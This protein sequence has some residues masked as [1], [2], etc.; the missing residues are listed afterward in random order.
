MQLLEER[1]I[2]IANTYLLH[3]SQSHQDKIV[4]ELGSSKTWNQH[5]KQKGNL[6]DFL[7]WKWR[8]RLQNWVSVLEIL[9]SKTKRK[10]SE[11]PSPTTMIQMST[12][13]DLIPMPSDDLWSGDGKPKW[14]CFPTNVIWKAEWF[15]PPLYLPIAAMNYVCSMLLAENGKRRQPR[16]INQPL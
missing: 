16:K 12:F 8:R 14:M 9:N 4:L 13:L 6:K 1:K 10:L 2:R 3:V 5:K 11:E 15:I 7:Q